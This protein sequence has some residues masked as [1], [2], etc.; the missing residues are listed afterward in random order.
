MRYEV[1]KIVNEDEDYFVLSKHKDLKKA[2]KRSL[3]IF[4]STVLDKETGKFLNT[5]TLNFTDESTEGK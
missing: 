1:I 5:C 2:E 4:G 3:N